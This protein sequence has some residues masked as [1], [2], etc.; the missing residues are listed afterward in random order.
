MNLKK[1][2]YRYI[3]GNDKHQ[4]NNLKQKTYWIWEN[5]CKYRYYV[6][7]K[8]ITIEMHQPF[9]LKQYSDGYWYLTWSQFSIDK[10]LI[11]KKKE[12]N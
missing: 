12:R 5:L 11:L 2:I 10:E 8:S 4:N 9:R 1:L 7:H 6:F 3:H